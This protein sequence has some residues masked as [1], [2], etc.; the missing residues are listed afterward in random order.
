MK[1]P[2]FSNVLT[3]LFSH[4]KNTLSNEQLQWLTGLDDE[5]D[6]Q[7]SNISE[8]LGRLANTLSSDDCQYSS[9]SE[10]AGALWMLQS[11]IENARTA[12]YVSAEA[13][14]ILKNRGRS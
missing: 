2:T 14:I 4:T 8:T 12:Y 10:L 7:L 11:H 13:Q 6:C 1:E 3:E 9:Q 5:A